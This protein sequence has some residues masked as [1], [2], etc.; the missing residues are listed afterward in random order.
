MIGIVHNGYQ[1][2]HTYLIKGTY[3]DYLSIT[4]VAVAPSADASRFV[5]IAAPK[6][7]AVA[8]KDDRLILLSEEDRL[9]T[10]DE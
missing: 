10:V 6:L 2:S 5:Q 9:I 7:V 1:N 4:S 3:N 8:N